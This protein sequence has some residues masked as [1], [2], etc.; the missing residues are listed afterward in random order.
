MPGGYISQTS[1]GMTGLLPICRTG[2]NS[3]GRLDS[4]EWNGLE[5]NS[6][7]EQYLGNFN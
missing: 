1:R 2:A 7:M 5:W 6:G 3:H 4:V